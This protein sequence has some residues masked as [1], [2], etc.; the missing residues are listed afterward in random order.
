MQI[1]IVSDVAAGVLFDDAVELGLSQVLHLPLSVSPPFLRHHGLLQSQVA[2]GD[3]AEGDNSQKLLFRVPS[4]QKVLKIEILFRSHRN[5]PL[6]SSEGAQCRVA[7]HCTLSV[8]YES[9]VSSSSGL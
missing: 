3:L 7:L 2:A 1:L 5:E 8:S 6:C 4:L 9:V